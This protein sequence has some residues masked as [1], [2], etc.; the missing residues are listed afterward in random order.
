M[1]TVVKVIHVKMAMR[2]L[3][4]RDLLL[5]S[6]LFDPLMPWIL[7]FIGVVNMFSRREPKWN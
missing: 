3:N 5:P 1:I 6:L 2:R 7:G 4:E